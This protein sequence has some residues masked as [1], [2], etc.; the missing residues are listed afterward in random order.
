MIFLVSF[1]KYFLFL[2]Y[3]SRNVGG[4]TTL[5]SSTTAPLSTV[6]TIDPPEIKI[7]N[8]TNSTANKSLSINFKLVT[9]TISTAT[10]TTGK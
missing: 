1:H 9:T 7:T 8:A 4:N 3:H 5:T 10:V 2:I 6:A